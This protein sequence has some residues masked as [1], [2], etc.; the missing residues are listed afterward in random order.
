MT[1]ENGLKER[2]NSTIEALPESS[3][4][5]VATF[6]E[7]L[8]YRQATEKLSSSPPYT[9]VALGGLW[10]GVEITEDDIEEIRREMYNQ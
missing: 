4:V 1:T 2:I 5:E 3:L 8:Q 7:Y 10:S 9:P 6:L